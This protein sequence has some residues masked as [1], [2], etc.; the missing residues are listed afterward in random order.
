MK[1]SER[2]VLV[3]LLTA[4]ALALR[5]WFVSASIVDRP[6][7]ADAAQYVQYAAN[8]E[9]HGT[10]SLSTDVPP[11]PD[12][13]RSPGYPA[14]LVAVRALA[15]ARWYEAVRIAQ[16][17]LGALLVLLTYR[18]ARAVLPFGAALGAAAWIAASP[19]LIAA[20]GYLL[21]EALTATL[22]TT[23]FL[24]FAA[25]LRRPGAPRGVATGLAF[26]AA[27]LVNEVIAPL[28][29]LLAWLLRKNLGAR[30]AL[31]LAVA[32]ALPSAAWQLRN[33]TTDLAATAQTRA[34]ATLSHGSYP[35]LATA[36]PEYRHEPYREDPEQPAF[37]ASWSGFWRVWRRRVAAEPGHY[38]R[39]YLLD[40][41]R[42]LWQWEVVQGPGDV[43]VYQVTGD[44]L[45]DQPV[46]AAVAAIERWSH[47]GFVAACLVGGLL[48][49]VRR[50]RGASPLAALRAAAWT[51]A[52]FTAVYTLFLPDPRYLV[53]VR[54]LQA[55]LA[56]T[57]FAWLL[58]AWRR[59]AARRS[60]AADV[61]EVTLP[62]S[63]PA[64]AEPITSAAGST[65]DS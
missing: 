33:A 60:A 24:L 31:A 26:G 61:V 49:F 64:A 21:T 53:P 22:S 51:L 9:A 6:L 18:L 56:A 50:C 36:N 12:A 62:A 17:I 27:A 28:P 45:R 57:P 10:F 29:L 8:L 16:A 19:H 20:S 39:W 42:W 2:A 1:R 34:V 5:L 30:A 47:P 23:A 44:I 63:V 59:R 35:D 15:G 55:V 37:G 3:G 41:P 52:W 4:V 7:R 11:R 54:P 40:K 14:F 25:T 46:V 65:V 13:V 38:A 48:A 32:A 58:A 43:Y